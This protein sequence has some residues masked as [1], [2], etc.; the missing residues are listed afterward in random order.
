M[1]NGNTISF[2]GAIFGS[3]KA[4]IPR[5]SDSSRNRQLRSTVSTK[6]LNRMSIFRRPNKGASPVLGPP[7]SVFQHHKAQVRRDC[8]YMVPPTTGSSPSYFSGADCC[9]PRALLNSQFPTLQRRV[10]ADD[11]LRIKMYES[12]AQVTLFLPRDFHGVVQRTGHWGRSISC[13]PSALYLK[14]SNNLRFNCKARRTE[15]RILVRTEKVLRIC[16]AG[17]DAPLPPS[18]RATRDSDD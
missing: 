7:R 8:A 11:V 15:D 3:A 14:E 2:R 1:S 5:V 13:S 9:L 18:G 16:V 17:D 12:Y 6:T 10:D 4:G